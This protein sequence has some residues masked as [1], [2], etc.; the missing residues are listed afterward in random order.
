MLFSFTA[1]ICIRR[2]RSV[3]FLIYFA[4]WQLVKEILE[5]H[6][7]NKQNE[8]NPEVDDG[9]FEVDVAERDQA[10][11]EDVEVKIAEGDQVDDEDVEVEIAEGDQVDD[12]D[13]EVEVA[14]GDQTDDKDV[15]VDVKE[16]VEAEVQEDV[17]LEIEDDVEVE[18]A[19][20]H[21][22]G[23]RCEGVR[24]DEVMRSQEEMQIS[25][26]DQVEVGTVLLKRTRS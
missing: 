3:F 15:D 8:T 2:N 6:D 13:V 11:D 25:Y 16:N 1:R 10:D 17:E 14:E 21:D 9:D 12:E 7:Q 23:L 5:K 24:V 22:V 18:E 4:C 20:V 26:P 19:Q